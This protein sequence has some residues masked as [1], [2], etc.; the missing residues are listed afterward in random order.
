MAASTAPP[1]AM[2][3]KVLR[4]P[5]P[6]SLPSQHF[7]YFCPL[8]HRHGSFRSNLAMFSTSDCRDSSPTFLQKSIDYNQRRVSLILV[9]SDRFAD[10][11]PPPGH[12]E[13]VERAEVM[14][15]VASEFRQRGGASS[16]PGR[17]RRMS[18]LACTTEPTFGWFV[19]RRVAPWRSTQTHSRHPTAT[20]SALL[21]A[22]AVLVAVEHV[23]DAGSGTRAFAMSASSGSSRRTQPRHG[24]LSLQQR[25]HRRRD[26]ARARSVEGRRRRHRRAPSE[27]GRSGLFTTIPPCCH[28]ISS[29]PVLPRH[30]GGR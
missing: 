27:T 13:G 16:S 12:P 29:V 7:L 24:L 15:V 28:L 23:L 1:T 6:R 14:Q 2:S 30:R 21:A 8:P 10:H 3:M 5:P 18:S 20:T 4:V 19:R 9:T 11:L 25:R 22:G 17:P 26:G